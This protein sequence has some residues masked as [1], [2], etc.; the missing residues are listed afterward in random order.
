MPASSAATT[1]PESCS[2][3]QP[4]GFGAEQVEGADVF[5][6]DDDRHRED[7]ADLE[8]EHGGAVDG[9]AGVVG[10]GEVDDQDGRAPGDGVQARALAEE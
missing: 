2:S 6:G 4:A 9:P 1:A 3:V 8:V 5:A 10:V 7:A